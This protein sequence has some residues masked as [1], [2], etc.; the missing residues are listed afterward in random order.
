MTFMSRQVLS[1]VWT[2]SRPLY[3]SFPCCTTS[4]NAVP[5]VWPMAPNS[6]PSGEVQ[7]YHAGLATV[8]PSPRPI[9]GANHV[10]RQSHT[11]QSF[12]IRVTEP[13]SSWLKK[14]CISTLWQLYSPAFPSLHFTYLLLLLYFP[15][16]KKPMDF[17]SSRCCNFMDIRRSILA[18][19]DTAASSEATAQPA[20]ASNGNVAEIFM[21]EKRR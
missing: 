2:G 3:S 12:A 19:F 20:A 7:P 4:T 11:Q 14:P 5:S 21:I 9:G 8:L 10:A 16:S 1:S 17:C 18:W 15:A 6:R 13:I